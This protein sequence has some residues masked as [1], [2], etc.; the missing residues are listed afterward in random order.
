MEGEADEGGWGSEFEDDE[1]VQE[2]DDDTSWKVRRSAI[3]TIDSII[4]ARP[5]LLRT[6]YQRYA[7]SLVNR[8]KERDANVKCDVL[9]TFQTLLKSTVVSESVQTIELELSHQPSLLRQRSSTDELADLVP[10]IIDSLLK[11]LN[12][13]NNKVR[14]TVMNTLASLAHALHSK[15][16][17]YFSK[18]LPELEKNMKEH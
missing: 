17:P 2:D 11:Q 4:S 12:S 3:K 14:V 1:G 13:K 15:L 5:E 10:V 18:I 16:E 7:K 6:L 8:F 9:I